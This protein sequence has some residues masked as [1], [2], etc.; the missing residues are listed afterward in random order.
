MGTKML[1]CVISKKRLVAG[2]TLPELLKFCAW[3][4]NAMIEGRWPVHAYGREKA[5]HPGEQLAD[6]WQARWYGLKGDLEF[7]V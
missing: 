2:V 5:L 3:S 7:L 6:G 1:I 4:I